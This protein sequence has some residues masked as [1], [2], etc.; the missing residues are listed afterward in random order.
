MHCLE[1]IVKRNAE[2]A[3]REAAHARQDKQATVYPCKAHGN[4]HRY[5]VCPVCS[6]QFCPYYW[7]DCPRCSVRVSALRERDLFDGSQP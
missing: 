6:H 4:E 7:R 5:G 3:T 1:G 2:A